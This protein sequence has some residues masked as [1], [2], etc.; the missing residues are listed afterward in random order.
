MPD[1]LTKDSNSPPFPLERSFDGNPFDHL[2]SVAFMRLN[3]PPETK[4]IVMFGVPCMFMLSVTICPTIVLEPELP[5]KPIESLYAL[6]VQPTP[7]SAPPLI[8]WWIYTAPVNRNWPPPVKST[9]AC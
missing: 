5:P 1:A 9:L 3:P 6:A 2:S 7:V 8:H 4:S